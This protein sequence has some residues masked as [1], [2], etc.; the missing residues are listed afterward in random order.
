MLWNARLIDKLIAI[1]INYYNNAM[2]AIIRFMHACA[3]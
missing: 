2:E 3:V 1:I